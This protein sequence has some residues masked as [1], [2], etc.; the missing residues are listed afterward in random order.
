MYKRQTQKYDADFTE[1]ITAGIFVSIVDWASF[2]HDKDKTPYWHTLKTN[3]ELNS[4]YP[5]GIE[6]QKSY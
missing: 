6:E 2:Q 1:P 3:G 4:K 5:N